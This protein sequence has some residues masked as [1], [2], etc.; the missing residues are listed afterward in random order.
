MKVILAS[1]VVGLALTVSAASNAQAPAGST[2][3]CKDGTY[4]TSES[5]RGARAAHGGV[6]AWYGTPATAKAQFCIA[7]APATAAAAAGPFRVD[8]AVQRWI[9]YDQRNQEGCMQ[10]SWRR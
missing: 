4:T 7:S 6:K 8:R 3:E 2:G 5:K 10:R 1:A 9:A